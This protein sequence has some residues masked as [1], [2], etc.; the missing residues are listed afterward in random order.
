MKRLCV[1]HAGPVVLPARDALAPSILPF[2][3]KVFVLSVLGL[4]PSVQRDQRHYLRGQQ[5]AAAAV[6]PSGTASSASNREAVRNASRECS[7]MR[8]AYN[9]RLRASPAIGMTVA[10]GTVIDLRPPLALIQYE[11]FGRQM[12]GR[13]QDWVQISSLSAGSDCPR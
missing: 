13:E 4:P 6:R 7:A 11:A 8:Q 3:A 5:A 10:F 9:E 12:K 1:L 2:D